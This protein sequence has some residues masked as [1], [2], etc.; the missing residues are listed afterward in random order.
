MEMGY[1]IGID[2]GG[3]FT[4]F[5]LIDDRGAVTLWKEDSTPEDPLE[6]ME[7]GLLACAERL[8]LSIG[9]LISS[10]DSFVHGSTIATNT[11][12]QRNGGPV[13][14][15]CTEGFRDVI[16][17]RDG[18]RP[19][20]FNVRQQR[21]DDFVDRHLRIG[22]RERVN[23]DGEVLVPLRS[24]DLVGAADVF[25]RS[26]VKA[27]AVAFLWSIVE[28]SHELR[29][30]EIL[31][32]ELPGVPVLCSHQ[33]VNEVREWERTSATVLSAYTLPKIGDYLERLERWLGS[34]G[35]KQSPQ[36]MQI[37]GGCGS[38]QEV[39][40]R[41][42]VTLGSG[43]AA[44]PAAAGYHTP[45]TGELGESGDAISVDMG[46]T[47]FDVCLM[48]GGAPA[49]SRD[50]QVEF[51]PI[52]VPGVEVESIGAGGGSIAWVDAGGA[53]HVGP[54]SAGSRP[55]PACYDQGGELPTVTDANV[56]LGYLAP[57]A[58]LS[59]RRRLL[60]DRSVAAISRE[61]AEPLDLDP[62]AAAAGM[63]EVVNAN[64]VGGI[65]AVS[66]ER[67]IDPRGF[68]L[69]C[70]GGA[71]GL[72][73]ARIA[74]QIG[75]RHIVIPPQASTLCA[76]GMTVTDVRHDHALS[77]HAVSTDFDLAEVRPRL[78]ELEAG[79]RERLEREGF[80]SE[81]TE[82]RRSV[83]ARYRGQIHEITVELPPASGS[84]ADQ[85]E[86]LVE[87]FHDRHETEFTYALRGS[88]VEFLH[89][90]TTA[91]GLRSADVVADEMNLPSSEAVPSS[92]RE[93][94]FAELGG[95]VST[96]VFDAA[97]FEP[98]AS[99]EGHAV[100]QASNTTIVLDPGDRLRALGDGR[101]LLEIG[102]AVAASDRSLLAR[103]GRA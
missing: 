60:T 71:G 36:Y 76:F 51:Q 75:I 27:V 66:V 44:A 5:V 29:A 39:M 81:Q 26:G 15:V 63:I 7:R 23:V 33:V 61:V 80:G 32:E 98:G 28:P 99:L 92:E 2:I 12:I 68:L 96:P 70:G 19:D 89:W 84:D 16:Y 72:H 64:M 103:E 85:L 47:S 90:R 94:Y 69:V 77:H 25:R 10:C 31:R 65:R 30:R 87:R 74:R 34:N 91:L 13:G 3:T 4:D 50:I 100:V 9:E 45:A 59:G 8:G 22:V 35:L 18:F 58:F 46:G 95:M 24:E 88:P 42:V 43:P 55:G 101:L 1:R 52:G 49:M 67:G 21:P 38:L 56:V 86:E 54:D 78:E 37:N 14:L 62:V 73:A 40:Q 57:E 17:F 53:L 48:R 82:I 83:D 102:L 6:A 11:L 79:A 97:E 41:P 93:A 20:R